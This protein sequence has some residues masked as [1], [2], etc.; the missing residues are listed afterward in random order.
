MRKYLIRVL[1]ALSLIV[2]ANAPAA[3]GGYSKGGPLGGVS[4]GAGLLSSQQIEKAYLDEL[5]KIRTEFVAVVASNTGKAIFVT[6]VFFAGGAVGPVIYYVAST[7]IDLVLTSAGVVEEKPF[8]FKIT[9]PWIPGATP[10][11]DFLSITTRD[12]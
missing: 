4:E 7:E 12:W 1:V 11:W 3:A 6:A 2:I 9:F 8:L 10:I 5:V